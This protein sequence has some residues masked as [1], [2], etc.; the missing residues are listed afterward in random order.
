MKKEPLIGLV[1]IVI[2]LLGFWGILRH[3]FWGT[4]SNYPLFSAFSQVG[5]LKTGDEV[6]IQ[7]VL[8]GHVKNIALG[9]NLAIVGFDLP[10]NI[11]IPLNSEVKIDKVNLFGEKCIN[12]YRSQSTNYYAAKD[13]IQGNP[14]D[15][16][17][18][19]LEL[20]KMAEAIIKT[21]G[22]RDR[23]DSLIVL[24]NEIK[25]QKNKGK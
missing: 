10:K 12:I 2:I 24:L 3:K 9:K 18:T 8:V 19:L 16:V 15:T 23:L 13:T 21:I 1:I 11:K 7:G 14:G 20:S 25:D 22:N 5:T 17:A 6:K 4:E